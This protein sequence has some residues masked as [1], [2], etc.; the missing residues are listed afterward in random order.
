MK[1]ISI[2]GS[3]KRSKY[4]RALYVNNGIRLYEYKEADI[5][6]TQIPFSKD[7]INLNGENI[8]IDAFVKDIQGKLL[9]SGA[10][11]ENIKGKFV[12]IE[13]Y[14]LTNEESFSLLNAIPTAEGA[15]FEA[16][17]N[18]ET[19]LCNSNALIMGYGKIGKVLAKMLN[20]IGANVYCEARKKKDLAF[21]KAMGY[22][23]IN[24]TE[25][26]KVLPKMDYIFNTVPALL[27]DENMLKLVKKDAIIIDLASTPGGVD[28]EKARELDLNVVWTL[29]LPTKVAPK[30]AAIYIKDTIDT[31]LKDKE[32]CFK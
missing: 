6:I 25:L 22:N 7:D 31:I 3:D 24:I 30:T 29:A 23:E 21:I 11:T 9:F 27:L 13:Y 17:K 8:K 14:D 18:T 32:I 1:K 2:L 20:G 15:I 4:L 28:F 12:N 19:T 26:K 16:I 5:V 10:Y